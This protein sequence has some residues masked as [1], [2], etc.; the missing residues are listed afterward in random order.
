MVSLVNVT[1]LGGPVV[2]ADWLGPKVAGRM[3][4]VLRLSSELSNFCSG[5]N[6][7]AAP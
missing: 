1:S 6:M 5:S 2:Q 7:L 4:L 3:M